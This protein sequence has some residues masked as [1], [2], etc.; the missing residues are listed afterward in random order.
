MGNILVSAANILA[1]LG[2]DNIQTKVYIVLGIG[3]LVFSWWVL[4]KYVV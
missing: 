1:D 4:L 3:I 2:G